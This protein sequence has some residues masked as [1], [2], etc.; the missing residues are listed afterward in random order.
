[1][2]KRIKMI[3][4]VT[5]SDDLTGQASLDVKP[6]ILRFE[7]RVRAIDLGEH[8]NGKMEEALAEANEIMAEARGKAEAILATFLARSRKVAPLKAVKNSQP[9]KPL[10]GVAL[11]AEL[12]RKR[13]ALRALGWTVSNKGK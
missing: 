8:N 10:S 2:A 1:M 3:E 9:G 5:Y 4:E 7:D 12:H 11:K 6:R 13:M